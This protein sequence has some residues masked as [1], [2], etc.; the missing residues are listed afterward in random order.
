MLG[1]AGLLSAALLPTVVHA[2]GDGDEF[3][4]HSCAQFISP[5]PIISGDLT[6]T[7]E[8]IVP[9]PADDGHTTPMSH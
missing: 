4:T 6:D 5:A 7:F 1:S 2:D 3:P 9:V 8:P